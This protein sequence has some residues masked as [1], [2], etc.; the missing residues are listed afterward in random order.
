MLGLGLKDKDKEFI[1]KLLGTF[2][3][4]LLT[5]NNEK[6]LKEFKGIVHDELDKALKAYLIREITVEK[7]KRKQGDPEKSI[8]KEVWNV[9][10]FM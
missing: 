6:L 3:D 7:S 4:N 2:V 9:F 8:E 10:D 1:E 5:K